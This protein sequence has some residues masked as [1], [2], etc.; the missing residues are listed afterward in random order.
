MLV[1]FNFPAQGKLVLV[2]LGVWCD[3][4]TLVKLL[5]TSMNALPLY[6]SVSRTSVVRPYGEEQI[7]F[8]AFPNVKLVL[9]GCKTTV[10]VEVQIHFHELKSIQVVLYSIEGGQHIKYLLKKCV[11]RRSIISRI[12]CSQRNSYIERTNMIYVTIYV[13][14]MVKSLKIYEQTNVKG[15]WRKKESPKHVQ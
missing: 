11:G 13:V 6:L 3:G 1:E 4:L 7:R 8:F 12:L 2:L 15:L 14:E 10:V 5:W 9:L